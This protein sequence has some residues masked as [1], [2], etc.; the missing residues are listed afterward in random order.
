MWSDLKR[1]FKMIGVYFVMKLSGELSKEK[2]DK[3][4]A[5]EKELIDRLKKMNRSE[6]R[7]IEK[8]VGAKGLKE[9]L[10]TK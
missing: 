8:R 2:L 5:E 4:D 10:Q 1:F 6:R 7:K 9:W 3:K